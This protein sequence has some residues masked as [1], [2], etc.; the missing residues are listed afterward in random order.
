MKSQY[1]AL[2]LT[3]VVVLSLALGIMLWPSEPARIAVITSG[4]SVVATVDLAKDQTFTV[5]APDGGT[6]MVT[7]RDGKIA[8]TAASCPD[9]HCMNRGFCHSGM[10]IVCLPNKL[11]ITFSDSGDVDGAVG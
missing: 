11:V 1:W 5:T 3:A 6:N 10:P 8:V 9:H 2:I 4:G 7:V